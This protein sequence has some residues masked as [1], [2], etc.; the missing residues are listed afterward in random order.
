MSAP[1]YP[2]NIVRGG[3]HQLV[4]YLKKDK[5]R[6]RSMVLVVSE[7]SPDDPNAARQALLTKTVDH[8]KYFL[9][10]QLGYS[11]VVAKCSTGP[12]PTFYDVNNVVLLAQRTGANC[13]AAL[14]TGNAMDLAKAARNANHNF[15]LDDMLFIPLTYGASIAALSTHSLMDDVPKQV[16]LIPE[17][18]IESMEEPRSRPMTVF[19]LTDRTLFD[20]MS[21]ADHAMLALL[22]MVLDC[23]LQWKRDHDLTYPKL[24]AITEE[25][26]YCLDP[27]PF[28]AE[29]SVD[30]RSIHERRLDLCHL[31]GRNYLSFGW[32]PAQP[33]C[34]SM[35]L[36]AALMP[37]S[38]SFSQY[39][40]TTVLASFAPAYCEI[41][42]SDASERASHPELLALLERMPLSAA[43]KIITNEPF[44][45][46]M[47]H[48][49]GNQA[50]WNSHDAE[51]DDA[52][53]RSLLK[54]HLF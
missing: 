49:H 39:S 33:R 19:A 35:A 11:A 24:L 54:H 31:V 36:A 37:V 7:P 28:R 32:H 43:P 25:I 8:V 47:S 6:F 45:S 5:S 44:D 18:E 38:P 4:S 22:T 14:G 53:Y 21:R 50:I 20:V 46:L 42:L 9:R 40:L 15:W 48:I 2:P 29:E 27:Q 13:V 30:Q 41:L 10:Q 51:K 3:L 16:A 17:P 34:M 52:F 12:F 26:L 23:V 1:V